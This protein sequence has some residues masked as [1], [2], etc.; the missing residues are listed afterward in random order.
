MAFFG[1]KHVY[2][3]YV[4][5]CCFL[6]AVTSSVIYYS[7]HARKNVIYS[8]YTIKIQIGAWKMNNKIWRGF[9][10]ICVCPL[11]ITVNNHA[12]VTLLYKAWHLSLPYSYWLQLFPIDCHC[13]IDRHFEYLCRQW[14]TSS[15]VPFPFNA[16]MLHSSPP[17]RML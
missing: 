8:F 13:K 14:L 6:H 12:E 15:P 4:T 3:G 9:D 17:I 1:V 16:L 2:R 5:I 10:V 7:T 11:I